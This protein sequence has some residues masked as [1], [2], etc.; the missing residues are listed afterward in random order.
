MHAYNGIRT[1]THAHTHAHA[2]S[3]Q[4]GRTLIGEDGTLARPLDMPP[5]WR[6][7]DSAD[8]ERRAGALAAWLCHETVQG[9]HSVLMF[10]SSKAGTQVGPACGAR[11][12]RR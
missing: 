6:D 5:D 8:H 4:V 1:R 12:G 7:A 2:C 9:G 11:G 10:C 3:L